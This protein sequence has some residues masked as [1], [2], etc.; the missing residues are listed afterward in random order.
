MFPGKETQKSFRVS[1]QNKYNNNVSRD[2]FD[3]FEESSDNISKS[4]YP[5]KQQRQLQDKDRPKK[6]PEF[7]GQIHID[8]SQH[9]QDEKNPENERNRD[10][11]SQKVET[12]QRKTCPYLS[13]EEHL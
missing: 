3:S 7:P 10:Y 9:Q 13:R 1:K 12:Q 5:N 4:F 11:D 8:I 6:R 2:I